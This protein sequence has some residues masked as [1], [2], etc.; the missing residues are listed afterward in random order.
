MNYKHS[1]FLC[2]C[3]W[4]ITPCRGIC[5][6][7][8][9]GQASGWT[10]VRHN[11]LPSVHHK[12]C[13]SYNRGRKKKKK[14]FSLPSSSTFFFLTA[15]GCLFPSSSPCSRQG[16]VSIPTDTSSQRLPAATHLLPLPAQPLL[17]TQ[18]PLPLLEPPAWSLG[19]GQL[20]KVPHRELLWP[21][22]L[23]STTGVRTTGNHGHHRHPCKLSQEMH[24]SWPCLKLFTFVYTYN[25]CNMMF[26]KYAC[27]S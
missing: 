19:S 20:Q 21:R 8:V 1:F 2:F 7:W 14:L 25:I 17:P 16:T 11:L 6:I 9:L 26:L 13:P 22:G 4:L 3:R 18:P 10:P 27:F 12:P 24:H 5:V 23:G 15:S